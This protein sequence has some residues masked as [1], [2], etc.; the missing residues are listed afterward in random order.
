ML[1]DNSMCKKNSYLWNTCINHYFFTRGRKFTQTNVASVVNV[2][3]SRV[4][5]WFITTQVA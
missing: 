2:V 3:I 4:K 1:F 5:K